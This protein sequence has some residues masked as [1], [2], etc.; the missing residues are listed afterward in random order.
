MVVDQSINQSPGQVD[1]TDAVAEEDNEQNGP[2]DLAHVLHGVVRRRVI[3]GPQTCEHHMA[4][5]EPRR[6][7]SVGSS[8]YQICRSR[9]PRSASALNPAEG[10]RRDSGDVVRSRILRNARVDAWTGRRRRRSCRNWGL[11]WLVA[12]WAS[13]NYGPPQFP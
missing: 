1:E 8:T 10:V 13:P 12:T 5:G 11:A 2:P 6:S 9:D 3:L 4:G 7:H